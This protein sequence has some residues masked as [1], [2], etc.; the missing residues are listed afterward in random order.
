LVLDTVIVSP[1]VIFPLA[2]DTVVEITPV[3]PTMYASA[4]FSM[5]EFPTNPA[6]S[7]ITPTI[8]SPR[9]ALW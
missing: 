6:L 3:N 7:E 5:L 9:T 4:I 1:A 8:G 2:F